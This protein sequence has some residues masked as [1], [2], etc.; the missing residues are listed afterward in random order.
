MFMRSALIV[1]IMCLARST[2]LIRLKDL[3]KNLLRYPD[4]QENEPTKYIHRVNNFLVV[5]N[6]VCSALLLRISRASQ[7]YDFFDGAYQK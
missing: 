5:T 4:Y 2:Y 3:N 6:I 1:Y 7:Q